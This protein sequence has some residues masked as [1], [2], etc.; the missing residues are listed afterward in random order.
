MTQL[1]RETPTVQ[2]TVVRLAIDIDQVSSID[3]IGLDTYMNAH[4][5]PKGRIQ[6]V[7][8]STPN[9]TDHFKPCRRTKNTKGEGYFDPPQV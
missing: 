9:L 3:S 1:Q 7:Q 6:I 2:R 8:A 4:W 5:I